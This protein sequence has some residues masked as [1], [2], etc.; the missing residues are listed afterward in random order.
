MFSGAASTFGPSVD[1]AF[2]FIAGVCVFMLVLITF[3]MVFFT[4]RYRRAKH[5]VSEN[6]EGNFLL[7]IVWTVIPTILVTVMFYYG[8]TGYRNM[9]TVPQ[10]AL[11]VQV[12][13]RMWSWQFKYQ[14]GRESDVL[15]VP[16]NRPVRIHLISADVL[17]SFYVPAFRIKKDAVP[18]E[19]ADL[20][21]QPDEIGSYDIF[22]AEYCGTGHSA[23]LSKVDVMT[24]KDFQAWLAGGKKSA[25]LSGK[26]LLK[27]KGCRGCHTIDG[28]PLV[29]PS[30]KGIFGRS[31]KVMTEGAERIVKIDEAY[32]RRS[33]LEPT[34]DVVVGFPPIM[35]SQKGVLTE[36][37]IAA[38][39]ET[40]KTL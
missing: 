33:M 18:G 11:T 5:P 19:P 39:I 3:F 28:T 35:P 21:F 4:I 22:C 17:H 7:E 38:I 30:F 6:I 12:T 2:L 25:P 36:E 29:G 37:E 23:M 32:L 26:G 27:T 13:G 40:F 15:H 8:W 14:N 34:A 10:N 31:I 20:W 24:E 9:V 1:S 16:L